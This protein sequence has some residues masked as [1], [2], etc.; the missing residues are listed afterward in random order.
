MTYNTSCRAIFNE[1]VVVTKKNSEQNLALPSDNFLKK[2]WQYC[3]W[4]LKHPVN[5]CQHFTD[6]NDLTESL[7][8]NKE[9]KCI[10]HKSLSIFQKHTVTI[11]TFYKVIFQKHKWIKVSFCKITKITSLNW[12]KLKLRSIIFHVFFTSLKNYVTKII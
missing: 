10:K 4:E 8:F 7:T 11:L 6:K 3:H 9:I 1:L 2:M 5:F 12:L